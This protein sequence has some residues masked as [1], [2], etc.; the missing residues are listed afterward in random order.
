[1]CVHTKSFQSCPI[2][3]DPM[4]CSLPGSSTHGILQARI[5]SALP[6]PPPGDPGNPGIEPESLMSPALAGRFFIS[7]TTWEAHLS[8][9]LVA[10]DSLQPHGLCS[11][12][13]SP[14]Q[15]TGMGSLSL[16]QGIFPTQ[17]SNPGV[18]HRRQILYQLCHQENPRKLEWGAY[19]FSSRSS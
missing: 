17:E 6:C 13:N 3:C 1:M 16:L 19:P 18:L 4:D 15:N 2:L 5:L 11:P 7:S 9:R 14:G 10:P 8:D 12:W